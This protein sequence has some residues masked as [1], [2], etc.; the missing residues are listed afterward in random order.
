[1]HFLGRLPAVEKAVI[2]K[3]TKSIAKAAIPP[4][5]SL[6]A[7]SKSNQSASHTPPTK[8]KEKKDII[9]STDNFPNKLEFFK[10]YI[11]K[12]PRITEF[13][14]EEGMQNFHKFLD[15]HFFQWLNYRQNSQKMVYEIKHQFMRIAEAILF[16]EVA[17]EQR[18]LTPHGFVIGAFQKI[19]EDIAEDS[20]L[21]NLGVIPYSRPLRLPQTSSLEDT[22]RLILEDNVRLAGI[23]A[24]VGDGINDEFFNFDASSFFS[25]LQ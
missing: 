11:Q 5:L 16:L 13:I 15:E 4:A 22:Q 7:I 19:L 20:E 24:S 1:V 14:G 12:H 21:F 9:Y 10:E 23:E 25:D 17:K 3:M 6:K 18:R 2:I 8:E